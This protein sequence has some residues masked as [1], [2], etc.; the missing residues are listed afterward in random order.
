MREC[1]LDDGV[2]CTLVASVFD[3]P[4][5]SHYFGLD[6][7]K[8]AG[9]GHRQLPGKNELLT[10]E[11]GIN[12]FPNDHRIVVNNE[13]GGAQKQKQQNSGGDKQGA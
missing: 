3:N 5:D 6:V 13:Q 11:V 8:I 10:I 4:S 12:L 1:L 2:H 7:V 9:D